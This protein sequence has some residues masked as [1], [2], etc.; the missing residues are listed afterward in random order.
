MGSAKKKNASCSLKIESVVGHRLVCAYIEVQLK[1]GNFLG[2]PFCNI[3]FGS[4]FI[5]LEGE[6][7]RAN[8]SEV[9][10]LLN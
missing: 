4:P 8:S 2:F 3:G 6:S 9:S 10:R 1:L 7:T 5:S